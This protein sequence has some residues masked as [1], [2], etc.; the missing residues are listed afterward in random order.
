M[1]QL[2]SRALRQYLTAPVLAPKKVGTFRGTLMGFMLGATTAG[3]AS[4]YYLVEEYK[5]ALAVIMT[6]VFALNDSLAK[7]ERHVKSLEEK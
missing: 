3:F 2:A 4:A 1:L 6:D 7:L 5:R